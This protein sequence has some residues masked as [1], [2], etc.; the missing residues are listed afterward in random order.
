MPLATR[1]SLPSAANTRANTNAGVAPHFA[2]VAL[3]AKLASLREAE[4]ERPRIRANRVC[5]RAAREL[6]RQAYAGLLPKDCWSHP[7]A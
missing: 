7:S 1:R 4:R 3:V 6:R 2:R 5:G